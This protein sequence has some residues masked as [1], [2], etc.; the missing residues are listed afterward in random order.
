MKILIVEKDKIQRI[1]MQHFLTAE[2]HEV[3][4]VNSGFLALKKINKVTYHIII[5]DYFMHCPI[6]GIKILQKAKKISRK[7]EVIFITSQN[8][9]LS[10]CCALYGALDYLKKPVN[11]NLLSLLLSQLQKNKHVVKLFGSLIKNFA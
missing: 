2:G 3:D 9:D 8:R 6:N 7:T 4:T 10:I 11:M 1:N 5:T